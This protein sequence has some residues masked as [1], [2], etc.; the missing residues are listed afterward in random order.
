MERHATAGFS[1]VARVWLQWLRTFS[2][3]AA[4]TGSFAGSGYY[5][6]D[7]ARETRRVLPYFELTAEWRV[8]RR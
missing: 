8:G 1:L 4:G 7:L 3:Y 5:A 2:T 6:I